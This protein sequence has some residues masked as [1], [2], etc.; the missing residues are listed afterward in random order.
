M[1]TIDEFIREYEDEVEQE[2]T[3]AINEEGMTLYE[4]YKFA[5]ITVAR[6]HQERLDI[7]KPEKRGG[8]IE[9]NPELKRNVS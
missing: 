5:Q 9:A 4:A 2:A 8:P 6:K 3:R 1:K 7:G